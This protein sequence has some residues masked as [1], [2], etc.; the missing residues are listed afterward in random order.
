MAI[1]SGGK[2]FIQLIRLSSAWDEHDVSIA[3]V[4]TSSCA[5]AGDLPFFN[6]RDVPR[7]DWWRIPAARLDIATVLLKVRRQVITTTGASPVQISRFA[8]PAFTDRIRALI[9]S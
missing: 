2:H 8:D 4:D 1:P 5:L 7:A 6:F 3:A 9:E